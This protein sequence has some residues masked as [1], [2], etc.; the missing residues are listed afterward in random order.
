MPVSFKLPKDSDNNAAA[1]ARLEMQM[2]NMCKRIIKMNAYNKFQR[3]QQDSDRLAR[4]EAKLSSRASSKA[5]SKA[6]RDARQDKKMAAALNKTVREVEKLNSRVAKLKE[7][8]RDGTHRSDIQEQV[9]AVSEQVKGL[10]NYVLGGNEEHYL[11]AQD[12]SEQIGQLSDKIERVSMNKTHGDQTDFGF[13]ERHMSRD[14]WGPPRDGAT[15]GWG[16]HS[17][18]RSDDGWRECNSSQNG[19]RRA[20]QDVDPWAANV[21]PAQ[22]GWGSSP[23]ASGGERYKNCFGDVITGADG[24]ANGEPSGWNV[25]LY[26]ECW[27]QDPAR[28]RGQRGESVATRPKHSC[29]LSRWCDGVECPYGSAA[30]SSSGLRNNEHGGDARDEYPRDFHVVSG[31]GSFTTGSEGQGRQTPDS[32]I[33]GW[34]N[35]KNTAKSS[36]D[37]LGPAM[38]NSGA[39][40]GICW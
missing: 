26:D 16:Q 33:G 7:F 21:E 31:N 35:V 13:Q 18:C 15:A 24:W 40:E 14:A 11:N 27:A 32:S 12:L 9:R 4:I 10:Q 22:G 29:F 6:A 36:T 37:S 39:F 8:S 34:H 30:S 5:S 38:W 1:I 20:K 28:C 19:G 17:L 25:P 2:M 3:M 23:N